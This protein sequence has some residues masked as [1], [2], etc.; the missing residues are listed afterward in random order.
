MAYLG[1]TPITGVTGTFERGCLGYWNGEYLLLDRT[2]ATPRLIR[3]SA[4]TVQGNPVPNLTVGNV[5]ELPPS[6]EYYGI[7][8]SNGSVVVLKKTRVMCDGYWSIADLLTIDINNSEVSSETEIHCDDPVFLTGGLCRRNLDWIFLGEY[9]NRN[10][11]YEINADNIAENPI[12]FAP[13]ITNR[14]ALTYDR[15]NNIVFVLTGS[16]KAL[17]FNHEWLR[18]ESSEDII[19]NVNNTEAVGIAWTPTSIAVLN[20]NPLGIYWYGEVGESIADVPVVSQST[21][22]QLK[23]LSGRMSLNFS[24]GDVTF[25]G[26]IGKAVRRIFDPDNFPGIIEQPEIRI[27]PQY[28]L[29]G[30]RA[31]MTITQGSNSYKIKEIYSL[32]NDY[33][34]SFLC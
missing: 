4:M 20:T 19:L 6:D 26:I 10:S 33:N 17:A 15:N 16:N 22:R 7:A 24:V 11:F 8:T 30:V 14:S 3:I 21:R 18:S 31:G 27:T 9:N 1:T 25:K 34:Q 28:V 23:R 29:E 5:I 13:S 2:P 32:N 12:V